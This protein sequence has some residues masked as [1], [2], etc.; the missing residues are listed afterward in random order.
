MMVVGLLQDFLLVVVCLE[1]LQVLLLVNLLLLDC[2]QDTSR[3]IL[4]LD[5]LQ[6]VLLLLHMELVVEVVEV[7]VCLLLDVVVGVAVLQAVPS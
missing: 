1:S 2:L 7:V 3:A 4:L 5:C 6:V